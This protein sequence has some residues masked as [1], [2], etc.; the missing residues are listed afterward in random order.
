[1]SLHCVGPPRPQIL[2]GT[3]FSGSRFMLGFG[4]GLNASEVFR[5]TD[6]D[7]PGRR[8]VPSHP[9]FHPHCMR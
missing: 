3:G 1:M 6:N 2:R 5:P 8:S 7:G 4:E 9:T